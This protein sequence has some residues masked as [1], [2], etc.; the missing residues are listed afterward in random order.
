MW[1]HSCVCSLD[2]RVHYLICRDTTVQTYIEAI[3]CARYSEAWVPGQVIESSTFLLEPFFNAPIQPS[4]SWL[5][6]SFN[7]PY[8]GCENEVEACEE[9]FFLM[10]T[11]RNFPDPRYPYCPRI[12]CCAVRDGRA[13]QM[14]LEVQSLKVQ[15]DGL[16]AEQS[17]RGGLSKGLPHS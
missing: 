4:N 7:F 1:I 3:L 14:K 5:E 10:S 17:D 6:D 16:L 13:W 11:E 12:P 2:F 15:F 9:C 8:S